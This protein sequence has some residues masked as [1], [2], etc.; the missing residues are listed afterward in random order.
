MKKTSII[1]LIIGLA[2]T[3][4]TGLNFITT[5]KVVDIGKVEI[6][7]DKK[8]RLNWSPLLGLAVIA[9]GAGLYVIGRTSNYRL[10]ITK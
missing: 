2:L 7:H 8:H 6:T 1:I 9:I 4:V 10:R 3:I 5:E